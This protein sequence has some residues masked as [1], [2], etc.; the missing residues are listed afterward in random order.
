MKNISYILQFIDR[1]RF[2]VCSFSNLVNNL[3]EGLHRIKFK[4]GNEDK[5]WETCI[6]KYKYC[7]SFLEYTTFKD[8]LIENKCLC[9]KKIINISLMKY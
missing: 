4:L 3:S 8:D 7:N 6:I 5:K 9:F 1:A 2:M